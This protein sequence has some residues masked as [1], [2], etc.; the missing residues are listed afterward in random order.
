MIYHYCNCDAFKEIV[1][2]KK[3]WV[4]DVRTTNDE[5]EYSKGF[6]I[7]QEMLKNELIGAHYVNSRSVQRIQKDFLILSVSFSNNG[8]LL[9]QWERYAK[10][11]TGISLGF[12]KEM[13]SQNN[14]F[15]QYVK[16]MSPVKS[17]IQFSEV[18]YDE[19]AFK[20]EVRKYIKRV[21]GGESPIKEKILSYALTRLALLYKIEFYSEEREVRGFFEI[22]DIERCDI[23]LFTRYC[24]RR[25]EIMYHKLNTSYKGNH[26]I[27]EVILGPKC[28]LHESE[29]AEL[30]NENGMNEVK[31]IKSKGTGNY[32]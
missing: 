31:I 20:N 26:S 1:K 27:R 19:K 32:R 29:V 4:S 18:I 14:L 21:E 3:I 23:D 15:N 2:T 10:L 12:D 17:R 13:V 6:S 8:D 28:M 11:S 7:I 5:G 25:G 16:S 22:D 9:S 30:L 24:E